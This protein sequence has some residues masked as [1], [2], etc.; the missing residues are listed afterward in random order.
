MTFA[1][2]YGIIYIENEKENNIILVH[3]RKGDQMK[4]RIKVDGDGMY[5][6][7]YKKLL[8]WHYIPGSMSFYM[9]KAKE[10]CENF[11]KK[12]KVIKSFEL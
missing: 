2:V 4:F 11:K 5:F 10:K 12:D 1:K 9:D 8:F 6:A 7:E 3:K